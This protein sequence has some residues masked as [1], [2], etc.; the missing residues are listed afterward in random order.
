MPGNLS[1][2]GRIW[3]VCCKKKNWPSSF[4]LNVTS[5]LTCRLPIQLYPFYPSPF[6][7][8]LGKPQ[9]NLVCPFSIRAFLR[10]NRQRSCES[11]A[12]FGVSD[13]QS[14]KGDSSSIVVAWMESS[15]PIFPSPSL[16][17]T[18][19]A[20]RLVKLPLRE[21]RKVFLPSPSSPL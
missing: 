19:Y 2:F 17:S 18:C 4:L 16:L 1:S 15:P 7:L 8:F 6:L 3:S 11:L 13:I 12:S 21:G 10:W 14:E 9:S 20:R 5:F